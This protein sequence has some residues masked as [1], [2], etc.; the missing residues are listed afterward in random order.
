MRADLVRAKQHLR[1]PP[2]RRGGTARDRRPHHLGRRHPVAGRAGWRPWPSR[3]TS[4]CWPATWARARPPSSRASP[5]AWASPSTSPAPPSSLARPYEGDSRSC[6]L[7][8]YRLEHIQELHD[9]GISELLDEGGVTVIEWGDVVAPALPADFL[10]VR[11]T[12]GDDDD[13]RSCPSAGWAR[14]GRPGPPPLRRAVAPWAVPARDDRSVL[15][16]R[17]RDRHPAGGLRHRR[18]RRGAGRV[19]LRPGPAPRGDARPRHR[20]RL[21]PGPGRAVGD[22]RHRRRHRA[23]AV[24]RAAGG[25]GHGQGHGPGPA[26]ADGG[27]LQ[28]RPA[29][30]PRALQQPPHRGGHRR[31]PG[32][33]VLRLLPPGPG[34]RPAAVALPAGHGRRAGVGAA[35]P[36][37]G[38]PAGGRR[39]RPLPGRP[40]RGGPLRRLRRRQGLPVGR[41]PWW[42]WP[43]PGPSGRSSCPPP[44]SCPSTCAAATPR[45]PGTS[46]RSS[47]WCRPGGGRGDEAAPTSWSCTWCPCAAATC[48]RCFASRPRCTPGRGRWACS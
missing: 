16:P 11:M 23:R 13:E 39:R 24:Q 26:G 4:S 10:E 3:A 8:V 32:R 7:D 20:V 31:P 43:I 5:G 40:A 36:G 9:L 14:A 19:P 29:G 12:P 37:R 28:P 34:R 45:S 17:H 1:A 25:R 21:P 2:S 42:S 41:R 48:G 33:G 38:V 6:H 46:G 44:T 18:P 27:G 15:D 35:G 22:L 30:L 47:R